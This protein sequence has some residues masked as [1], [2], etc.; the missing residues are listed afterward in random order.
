MNSIPLFLLIL[1]IVI[2]LV[3]V[4]IY[5]FYNKINTG[6]L[7]S[8]TCPNSVKDY[9]NRVNRNVNKDF[10]ESL[11]LSCVKTCE[12]PFKDVYNSELSSKRLRARRVHFDSNKLKIK[13]FNNIKND[14]LPFIAAHCQFLKIKLEDAY[15][16]RIK[17]E[18]IDNLYLIINF[19]A[20]HENMYILADKLEYESFLRQ[21][22]KQIGILA[23]CQILGVKNQSIIN[24]YSSTRPE[25]DL[26]KH[27]KLKTTDLKYYFLMEKKF[28]TYNNFDTYYREYYFKESLENC[29]LAD[30]FNNPTVKRRM[31]YRI[32]PTKKQ[33][34]GAVVL[35]YDEK[36]LKFRMNYKSIEHYNFDMIYIFLNREHKNVMT[37]NI[38]KDPVDKFYIAVWCAYN[39]FLPVDNIYRY[40]FKCVILIMDQENRMWHNEKVKELNIKEEEFKRWYKEILM[41]D[42]LYRMIGSC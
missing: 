24:Q 28:G 35:N 4:N 20:D 22:L 32:G 6:A 10:L 14:I 16:E 1:I 5:W 39:Y 40:W 25:A 2:V 17:N 18:I 34:E 27:R 12:K 33:Q 9:L 13:K 8:F 19:L 36:N 26:Y 38:I 23:L 41:N 11:Y 37:T 21:A 30:A 31:W 7:E 3:C 42:L 29:M 15:M